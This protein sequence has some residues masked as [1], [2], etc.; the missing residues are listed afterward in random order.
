MVRVPHS[1]R[2]AAASLRLMGLLGAA[3]LLAPAE[4]W[5]IPAFARQFNVACSTC[6]APVPPRLNN[7]G[8]VFKRLGYRMPDADD[9][10]RLV[11][12]EKPSRALFDDFSLIGDFR[13]ENSRGEPTAFALHEAEM[14]GAGAAGRRL[15]YSAQVAWEDGAFELEGLEGQVLLGRPQAN[16]TARFGLL[17]P[18]LWDKFG[19]QRL[20]VSQAPLAHNR[21]PAG[22][23]VGYRLHGAQRGVELG[24][25]L[26]R[27]GAEG[28]AMRATF[29]AIG[30][31]N[32]LTQEGDDLVFEENNSFK[33]VLI[34]AMHL[35]GDSNTIAALWYRGKATDIG[36]EGFDDAYDRWALLG[37]YRL[38]SGTDILGGFSV[39][40]D[41]TTVHEVGRIT[42][43]SWFLELNQAI[44]ARTAAFVRYDRFEPNRSLAD[45]TLRGPTVGAT[46]QVF[47]NLLLT[48]EYRGLRSG[49][50]ER[51]RDF[52]VRAIV[53]Y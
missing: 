49:T 47:D 25:N 37:N 52:V 20:S 42:S 7:L 48:A 51:G 32:G 18:L 39:G 35:W 15:S 46:H 21:V 17:A 34:Q 43:R 28:G 19:H 30:I 36:A 13:G 29:L 41:D 16:F 11:L 33:D 5:A 26:T 22:E 3:S 23:F 44:A 4:A 1:S 9:P 2:R 38:R 50:G 53:I 27:L 24:L 40:R 31:Y 14:M 8:I 45:A 6:H 12:R 10:G